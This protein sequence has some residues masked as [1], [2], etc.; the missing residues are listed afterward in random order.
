MRHHYACFLLIPAIT[1]ILSCADSNEYRHP[2]TVV[3]EVFM[4]SYDVPLD[5]DSPA[6]WNSADGENLLI[7][8]AKQGH[9]LVVYDAASGKNI[10]TIGSLGTAPGD[11]ARPN[12]IAVV[13]SLL[14][15]V[16]RDNARVQVFDL[17]SFRHRGFIGTSALIR[18]YGIFAC[19]ADGGYRLYITDNY[20]TPDETVPPDSELGKR[21]WRYTVAVAGDTPAVTDSMAFGDTGGAGVL[22]TVETIMGDPAANRI[23]IVDEQEQVL[24]EYTLDG[25]FTRNLIGQ[26]IF[27]HDPEGAVRWYDAAGD[28]WWIMT[29][30]A[31]DRSIFHVFDG[32]S[33]DHIGAFSGETT[34][35]TDGVAITTRSF[36]PFD[37]GAFY[38]VHNDGGVAA[39]SLADI[40]EALSLR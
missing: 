12:G 22:H 8:T 29:D 2:A 20:E 31:P 6:V 30:Q 4:T 9:E 15:V 5:I 11:F 25:A 16:E 32:A 33:L 3:R 36:G 40:M 34:A 17:P 7:A 26:G 28:G 39:F 24:K 1:L 27:Q 18:P 21:V 19:A 14:F 23:L 38:A 10:R 37:S 13:D 35:N